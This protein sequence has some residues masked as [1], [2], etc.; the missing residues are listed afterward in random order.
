MAGESIFKYVKLISEYWRENKSPTKLLSI[1]NDGDVEVTDVSDLLIPEIYTIKNATVDNVRNDGITYLGLTNGNLLC[2]YG[3]FGAEGSDA[4]EAYIAG[5]ISIDKGVT[6]GSEFTLQT[7]ISGAITTNSPSLY[8]TGEGNVGLLYLAS[9]GVVPTP[10]SQ[11]Y[12]TIFNQSLS[13]VTPASSLGLPTGYYSPAN[14]GVFRAANGDL[15]YP[16]TVLTGGDGTSYG[17]TYKGTI[18]LSNDGGENW[19]DL[20][21]DIGSTQTET[22]NGVTFGGAAEPRIFETPEGLVYYFRTLKK[23]TYAV[24]LDAS[25]EPT[26]DE[27]VLFPTANAT[28]YILKSE[29]SGYYIAAR[30]R[31]LDNNQYGD[32]S[33]KYLDLLSSVDGKVWSVI[34]VIDHAKEDFNWYINQPAIIEHKG[35]I[36]V[37]YNNS[38]TGIKTA[39]LFN[40]IYPPS[41]INNAYIPEAKYGVYDNGRGEISAGIQ[42]ANASDDSSNTVIKSYP[43]GG[44]LS[45]TGTPDLGAIEITLPNNKN[46]NIFIKGVILTN[47]T[48]GSLRF[49]ISCNPSDMTINS[50]D[51]K[52]YEIIKSLNV[53]FV[54]GTNPKILI[55]DLTTPWNKLGF[56]ITEVSGFKNTRLSDIETGWSVTL[57]NTSYGTVSSTKN[58]ADNAV[59]RESTLSVLDAPSSINFKSTRGDVDKGLA[60][61]HREDVNGAIIS[62]AAQDV[63]YYEIY[64]DK[65]SFGSTTMPVNARYRFAGRV[66]IPD[67]VENNEAVPLGQ[68]NTSIFNSIRSTINTSY[69][70]IPSAATLNSDYP[71]WDGKPYFVVAPNISGSPMIFCKYAASSWTGFSGVIIP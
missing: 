65:I 12:Q 42:V 5:K 67:A 31:L 27:Y 33:R 7:N 30:T 71:A 55:G 16:V 23:A 32:N 53:R 11:I 64:E 68:M 15:L 66:E 43:D 36:L 14:N 62:N 59:V 57:N 18:L 41:F 13:V 19:T 1:N 20:D 6:W 34:D 58:V 38:K 26:G 17:S 61:G 54:N 2:A 50:V 46:S 69:T 28:S 48:D 9:T 52:G 60:I 51:I 24:L 29:L 70:S 21:L 25:Y 49:D 4:D 37:G 47:S 40:K 3:R 22:L 45:L 10:E 39:S 56:A 63:I 35:K 8:E 44:T